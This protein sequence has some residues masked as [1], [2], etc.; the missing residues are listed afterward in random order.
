MT[1]RTSFLKRCLAMAV[2]LVLMI[3][4]AAPGLAVRA[5]AAT[6]GLS[7]LIVSNYDLTDAEKALLN[8]GCLTGSVEYTDTVPSDDWVSVNFDDQKI[9]AK[10][11]DGWIPVNANV[12]VGEDAVDSVSF[13]GQNTVKHSYEGNAY[14]VVVNYEL[15]KTVDTAEQQAMLDVGYALKDGAANVEILRDASGSLAALEVAMDEALVDS[16]ESDLIDE[17]ASEAINAIKDEMDANGG[18]LIMTNLLDAYG[19]AT[20]TFVKKGAEIETALASETMTYIDMIKEYCEFIVKMAGRPAYADQISE[21]LKGHAEK[22]N[23]ILINWFDAVEAVEGA[24]W[25]IADADLINSYEGLDALVADL[26]GS[27][28]T[29]DKES[30]YIT[31]KTAKANL[32][33]FNVNVQIFHNAVVDNVVTEIAV[34]EGIYP[35]SSGADADAIR[36]AV[37]GFIAEAVEDLA[38]DVEHFEAT[39]SELPETL[40][41]DIVY[42]VTYNPKEYKVIYEYDGSEETLPYGYKLTLAVHEENTKAY[43]YYVNG[44]KTAQGSEIT[45]EGKTTI[46]RESGTAYEDPKSLY[47]IVA[48]NYGS[49]IE[50]EILKSGAV[51]GDT[52]INVRMPKSANAKTL[53]T[54]GDGKLTVNEAGKAFEASYAGLYWTPYTYG[55]TA[56]N[57]MEFG[58]ETTVDFASGENAVVKYILNLTNISEAEIEEIQELATALK[59]EAD[60]QTEML[61]KLAAYE[62]TMESLD[63]TKLGAM[64]GVIGVTDFTE[65]DGTDTDEGNLKM[66][67]AFKEIVDSMIDNNLDADN[68]LKIYHI[69]KNYND[70]NSG[71]LTYY[72]NDAV[73]IKAEIESLAGYLHGLLETEEKKAALEIMVKAAGFPEYADKIADL[74]GILSEVSANLT[75]PNSAI[76]LESESAGKLIDALESDKDVAWNGSGYAWIESDNITVTSK[77]NIEV[78]VTAGGETNTFS[79]QVEKSGDILPQSYVDDINAKIDAFL[80]ERLNKD[81]NDNTIFYSVTVKDIM[82]DA[83][84]KLDA[85]AEQPVNSEIYIFYTYTPKS[86][87]VKIVDGEEIIETKTVTIEN[88]NVVLPKYTGEGRYAYDYTLEGETK[89]EGATFKLTYEQ[90]KKAEELK[91]ER[92]IVDLNVE[93]LEENLNELV[94]NASAGN[95][96]E[97][98]K[99]SEGNITGL[100]ANVAANQNGLMSF[101]T[102]LVN[103]GYSYIGFNGEGF[104][105]LN[106]ENTSEA[107]IQTLVNALLNDET[108]TN[109]TII[110]LG[111]NGK[112]KFMKT[113]MQLGN[114]ADE[115]LFE[116]LNFTLNLVE[117]PAQMQKVSTGLDKIKDY[118]RF[119]AVDG[120]LNVIADLP[121]KVYEVYLTAMVATSELDKT[122]MNAINDEIAAEFLYDYIELVLNSDATTTTFTNTLA[123]LGMDKDLTGY[124]GYY[125][126]LKDA[127][128]D[129]DTT[130]DMKVNADKDT[131]EDNGEFDLKVTAK[132]KNS[133]NKLLSLMGM[134]PAELTEDMAVKLAMIKEYKEGE[135]LNVE[136]FATLADTAT[137]Y[138]ALVLDLDNA[139]SNVTSKDL[140]ATAAMF[141]YT[142]DVAG[143]AAGIEERGAI[144]LLDDVNGDLIIPGTAIVDLNGKKVTG[145]I[146]SST[147]DVYVVDSCLGAAECGEVTV[148]VSGNVT[149]MGGKYPKGLGAKFMPDF[150]VQ[151]SETGVVRNALY[152][153]KAGN[154]SSYGIELSKEFFTKENLK[155]YG[156]QAATVAADVAIDIA[157]NFYD[158]SALIVNAGGTDYTLMAVNYAD[159]LGLIEGKKGTLA[160]IFDETLDDIYFEDDGISGLANAIIDDLLAFDKLVESIKTAKPINTYTAVANP[161]KIQIDHVEDGDYLTVGLVTDS[162]TVAHDASVTLYVP[163]S[164]GEKIPEPVVKALE[165]LHRITKDGRDLN[166]HLTQPVREGKDLL[167]GGK[168]DGILTVD[169]TATVYKH[170]LAIALANGNDEVA[171]ELLDYLDDQNDDAMKD[172]VNE[173]SVKDFLEAAAAL[174]T[175][176]I[177]E[178]CAE[179]KDSTGVD[180]SIELVQEKIKNK[181]GVD[182]TD[183]HIEQVL[184]IF[185]AGVKKVMNYLEGHEILDK[186]MGG[187][188]VEDGTY[189]FVVDDAFRDGRIEKKGFGVQYD[190]AITNATLKVHIFGDAPKTEEENRGYLFLDL[191]PLSGKTLNDIEKDFTIAD[192]EGYS[193]DLSIE[194]NDGTAIVKNGDA[195]KVTATKSTTTRII[196][197]VIVVMGDTNCNGIIENGDITKMRAMYYAQVS[198]ELEAKYPEVVKL[199]ADTNLN[200]ILDNGDVTRTRGQYHKVNNAR[201]YMNPNSEAETQAWLSWIDS[202]RQD[203]MIY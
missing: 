41:E 19:S 88:P 186:T 115:I 122:D 81:G 108:F 135:T 22:L 60:K 171:K 84:D 160:N 23:N 61:D 182:I 185:G 121:E 33:M 139:V 12:M 166:I 26:D 27:A 79:R 176:T 63:K 47:G 40:T 188:E 73:A 105:Y 70:E 30:L 32:N 9:T 179:V 126:M 11:E 200:D 155:H 107:S 124:E 184:E 100:V 69:V 29:L 177:E 191:H 163:A 173:M 172:V 175:K 21:S 59:A 170:L 144:I 14:N 10:S 106:D 116:K 169:L 86:Y 36:E 15:Y 128:S 136:A 165:E 74:E 55:A 195:L 24:T 153:L 3:S 58:G 134:D 82:G 42:T 31:Q 2:A 167:V 110:E 117:V 138:K 147:G 71:G 76:D 96:Y 151:D 20:E 143:A 92:S 156:L 183:D 199:A 93:D 34:A 161:W 132:G 145:Q 8:S 4:N 67:A 120:R 140:E 174:D 119:Q 192:L 137:E 7:D 130:V 133:I 13:E 46:T 91:I 118:L 162:K 43:D 164:V 149:V 181:F 111:K 98:E 193:F 78:T 53:M 148:G 72:Y 112:G 38:I 95:S 52:I 129:K 54:L 114:D 1:R 45:I 103:S 56:D 131:E 142:A 68:R 75:M 25:T 180:I 194:G 90:M 101:V 127:L 198:G 203:G 168:A 141:N 178:L 197:Y 49:G 159:I 109:E 18:H 104:V 50:G 80:A 28:T 44:V 85:Y 16:L 158:S 190:L 202:Y 189:G 5:S 89:R 62:T 201:D 154:V 150:Y 99:D 123:K 152:E 125:Q 157:L 196:N 6:V 65:G 94:I 37:A 83:A 48:D 66:R 77:M 57:M 102:D 113:N 39:K 17:D 35:L 187:I 97:I 87:E 64:N 146:S 51:K